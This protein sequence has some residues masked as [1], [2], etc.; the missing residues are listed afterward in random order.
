M[1]ARSI[2]LTRCLPPNRSSCW[3]LSHMLSSW[4]EGPWRTAD[5][6]FLE[7]RSSLSFPKSCP[8]TWFPSYYSWLPG[9]AWILRY[10]SNSSLQSKSRLLW[11][12]RIQPTDRGWCIH[13]YFPGNSAYTQ[14]SSGFQYK[15][16]TSCLL[17][18][19]FLI[20]GPAGAHW[21][22]MHG[23]SGSKKGP[24]YHWGFSA[25]FYCWE[26]SW[27]VRKGA[28]ELLNPEAAPSQTCL[29]LDLT[30]SRS[31]IICL[32]QAIIISYLSCFNPML[33]V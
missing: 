13:D 30:F 32:N 26:D 9:V 33:T 6:W 2:H 11:G 24:R 4:A 20:L 14:E 31:Y 27:S 29:T 23:F 18:S 19:F 28:P 16:R 3:L 17:R 10:S 15:Q 22:W 25:N 12:P 7:S 1:A 8:R 21:I 5:C